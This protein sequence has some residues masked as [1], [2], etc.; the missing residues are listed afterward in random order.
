M[1]HAVE[2]NLHDE[3]FGRV[4]ILQYMRNAYVILVWNLGGYVT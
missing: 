4:L 3:G 1:L 2:P